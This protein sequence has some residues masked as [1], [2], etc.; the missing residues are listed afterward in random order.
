MH[1]AD[2][3]AGEEPLDD[4]PRQDHQDDDVLDLRE[5][6]PLVPNPLDD[7]RQ[8]EE[9]Q[10]AADDHARDQLD[11]GR[12]EHDGGE[13]DERGDEP[14]GPRVDVHALRERRQAERVIP[15]D[16]AERAGDDVE[17][18]GVAELLVRVEV[19]VQ[20]ELGAADVE[21]DPD[22]GDEHHGGDAGGLSEHRPPVGAGEGAEGPR[23]EQPTGPVGSDQ[24]EPRSRI[25]DRGAGHEHADREQ[26][27]P[28]REHDRDDQRPLHQPDGEEQDHAEREGGEPV[29]ERL[30]VDQG[31]DR[32]QVHLLSRGDVDAALQEEP[33]GT[34][35]EAADDRIRHEPDQ[36]AALE[37]ARS[38]G[39]RCPSGSSRPWSPRRR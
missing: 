2:H 38:P 25:V 24:P 35:E 23:L 7:E 31:S 20:H 12:A 22:H 26:R 19:A 18:T 36:V 34:G 3:H 32:A 37:R 30:R 5:R 1:Q 13:R 39:T 28:G 27:E 6:P 16:T 33:S 8:A 4:D 21:Q 17:E 9:H 10:H 15:G 11:H 29:R 14:R